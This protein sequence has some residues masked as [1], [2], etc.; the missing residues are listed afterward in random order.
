MKAVL[1][2]AIILNTMLLIA[3]ML[4]Y[5]ASY[6]DP[7]EQSLPQVFGLFMPWLLLLNLVFVLFWSSVRKKWVLLPLLTLL[8]GIG[9]ITRFVG[10]HFSKQNDPTAILVCSYNSESYN[11]SN[12]LET[13]VNQVPELSAVDVLCL[14]EISEDHL[15]GLQQNITLPN[16]H[17]FKGKVIL[18]SHPILAKGHLQFDQSVN[19]CLWIDMDYNGTIIRVYNVHLHSNQISREAETIVDNIN[20]NKAQAWSKIKLMVHNYREAGAVRSTQVK[21]ILLHIEQSPHPV[22]LGGD[23]NDTPFSYTYQQFE[24]ELQDQFKNNGLG[25]GTTFAGGLPSL[26]IDYIFAD[27]NFEGLSHRIVKTKISDHFP[28][29]SYLKLKD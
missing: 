5:A 13:F 23:F 15:Q 17:F 8:L 1:K 6:I 12:H 27:N 10:F 11:R 25:I 3:T 9:Q 19:G 29:L 16:S 7:T 18:T 28:L 20:S 14:Q 4:G 24:H 22:I 21:E 2:V 26:K